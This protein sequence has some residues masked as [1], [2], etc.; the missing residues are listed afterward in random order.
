MLYG[1]KGYMFLKG[2]STVAVLDL[3]VNVPVVDGCAY[4]SIQTQRF[5]GAAHWQDRV[6]L[7]VR[8]TEKRQ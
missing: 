7:E 4:L 2:S 1:D 8:M 5:K 3:V 6:W